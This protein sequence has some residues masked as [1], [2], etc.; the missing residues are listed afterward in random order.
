[1]LPDK[2]PARILRDFHLLLNRSQSLEIC[3]TE[4]L[5]RHDLC[6]LREEQ[7]ALQA[8]KKRL[9]H[10][11]ASKEVE[12]DLSALYYAAAYNT[13]E[14]SAQETGLHLFSLALWSENCSF[15]CC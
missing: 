15:M 7:P 8:A 10:N 9:S 14:K 12:A 11:L 1:M 2:S 13:A 3:E 6:G 5:L 4:K